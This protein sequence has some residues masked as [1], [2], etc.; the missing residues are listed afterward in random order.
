[1]GKKNHEKLELNPEQITPLT[2]PTV[3]IEGP[4]VPRLAWDSKLQYFF[5][6][7]SYAVGLGNVWRFPYLTQQH[8]GGAF[9]IPYLVMLFAEGMPLLYLELAIGQKL[10][11]GSVGVWNIVHPLMGGVGLAS[12]VTS[13][14]VAIYYNAIIMWCFYYLFN[15]FQSPLPWAECPTET[16]AENITRVVPECDL[17][18]PTSYFWYRQA[19]D[20]SPGLEHSDGIKW[21]MLLSLLFSWL[22]VY[23]CIYKG[24]KSSGKVVYFTAT[25]PYV[26][27]T[28]FFIRGLTLRGAADGLMHMLTPKMDYLMNPQCW[29][30]AATQIFF[31]FGLAFGGLIAFSSYNPIH[32]NVEKDAILVSLCNWF[33]AIFA[34]TVIFSIMGFKATLMYEHC[35]E[36]NIE[37]LTQILPEWN[38]TTLTTTV[39]HEMFEQNL[40]SYNTTDFGASFRVCSMEDDLNKGAEGTGL[41]FIVF[42]QAIVEFGPSAPFWSI[43]FFLMLLSLGLGSEFGTIEGVATSLYDLDFHPWLRKKWLVSGVLCGSCCLIGFLFVLGSG[44]YWV[45][46]F[47]TFAGSY[48]LIIVALAEAIGVSWV[49]GMPRFSRDIEFMIGHKPRWFWRIAWKFV[50]PLLIIALL[51]A[52][53]VYQF[54]K[55][56]TYKAYNPNKGVLEDQPYP[57]YAGVVCAFL[58]LASV[59]FLPGVALLRK[60]GI[61]HYDRA[62]AMAADLQGTTSSTTKFLGSQMSTCSMEQDGTTDIEKPEP[63]KPIQFTIDDFRASSKD[64]AV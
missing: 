19:L 47:D 58:V 56:V 4:E 5:M 28:I 59:L 45:G 33:T 34:C 7:I 3:E 63:E 46:L 30:D 32:N 53:F 29:L 23:I 43:V 35:V 8:G 9:L 25:F 21:K 37:L 17:A 24:I 40:T 15:S 27:L 49:Y 36:H 20:V 48:P 14:M 60:L 51:I 1:M 41:A 61:L 18:G 62:K 64:S 11:R 13:Y 22:I 2:Q 44:F 54:S 50:A 42:T 31:S 57:W 16:I 55:P 39:Y 38:K 10:Q 52:T 12:A 26:V 6:V